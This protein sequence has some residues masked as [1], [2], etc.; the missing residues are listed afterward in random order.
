MQP[1][2]TFQSFGTI[3][4]AM[5]VVAPAA[6]AEIIH[7]KNGT[8]IKGKI[9]KQDDENFDVQTTQGNVKIAKFKVSLQDLPNPSIAV[10]LG[11]GFPGA[12]NA[13]T[14]R[15]DKALFYI[16]TTAISFAG[17]FA[18]GLAMTGNLPAPSTAHLQAGGIAG[19]LTALIPWGLGA[20]EA[21][22]DANRQNAE[23]KFKIEYESL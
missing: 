14:A 20:W 9:V 21:Y 3:A 13:Y 18:L 7:L 17:A 22:L 11:I 8:Q 1:L 15:Y 6:F 16:G 23:P 5:A 19:G 10:G 12:G 4:L 2:R